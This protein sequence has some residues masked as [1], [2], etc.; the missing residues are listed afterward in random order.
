MSKKMQI[1][2]HPAPLFASGRCYLTPGAMEWLNSRGVHPC[3]LLDRHFFGDDGDL[4]DDDRDA[5]IYAIQN[6]LRVVSCYKIAGEKLY[7]ITEAD[8]SS[9]TIL[10]ADE[11]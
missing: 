9:T 6:D 3:S 2:L 4:C 10:L 7:V 1:N 11:Y 5:N 8:R